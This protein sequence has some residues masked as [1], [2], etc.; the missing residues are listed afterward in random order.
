MHCGFSIWSANSDDEDHRSQ[1]FSSP[2]L[3]NEDTP[4][5]HDTLTSVIPNDI[6]YSLDTNT[7]NMMGKQGKSSEE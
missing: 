6:T 1:F 5:G 3:D 2:A 7:L 4:P